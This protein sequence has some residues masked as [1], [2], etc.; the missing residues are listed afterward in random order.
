M[1]YIQK[2][3][4]VKA[5]QWTGENFTE[6]VKFIRDN[7]PFDT[8]DFTAKYN[9]HP[10]EDFKSLTISFEPQPR[11]FKESWLRELWLMVGYWIVIDPLGDWKIVAEQFFDEFY[12][13]GVPE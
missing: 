7:A 13:K 5:V 6:V 3:L 12:E 11:I 4:P 9:E 2:P 10:S 1:T 8:K